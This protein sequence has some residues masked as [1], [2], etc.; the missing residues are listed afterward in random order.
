MTD[1]SP[2]PDIDGK[3]LEDTIVDR[4]DDEDIQ[5]LFDTIIELHDENHPHPCDIDDVPIRAGNQVN[6]AGL[7]AF[8]SGVMQSQP[9]HD[10]TKEPLKML[11]LTYHV[12]GLIGIDIHTVDNIL[13]SDIGHTKMTIEEFLGVVSDQIEDEMIESI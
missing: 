4:L 9:E 8:L 12:A 3:K 2:L 1:E 11:T 13:N 10:V 5:T 6:E 7:N